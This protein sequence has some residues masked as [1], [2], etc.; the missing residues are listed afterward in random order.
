MQRGVTLEQEGVIQRSNSDLM[1]G[2]PYS[3]G[4]RNTRQGGGEQDQYVRR[5]EAKVKGMQSKPGGSGSRSY[6]G[7]AGNVKTDRTLEEKRGFTC[8]DWNEGERKKAKCW[9]KHQCSYEYM[10]NGEI[11]ICWGPHKKPDHPK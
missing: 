10:R 4:S 6:Q 11:V 9:D 1:V 3:G 7:S 5:L 2:D 8:R